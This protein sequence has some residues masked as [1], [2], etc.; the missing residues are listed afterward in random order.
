LLMINSEGFIQ[1]IQELFACRTDVFAVR[2]EKGSK[3]GYWPA[4]HY[5]PYRFRQHKF[6]GGTLNDFTEKEYKALTKEEIDKHLAGEQL[7]GIY[8]LLKDNTSWFIAADFDGD[9]W[10]EQSREF[11]KVCSENQIHAYLERSRS[12]NGGHVW[13]FFPKPYPAW[14]SRKVIIRLLEVAGVLSEFDKASSFDR[15]FPNQDILSGKGFGNL[16]AMPFNKNALERGNCCF[17]DPNTLEPCPDQ[18]TFLKAVEKTSLSIMDSLVNSPSHETTHSQSTALI[19]DVKSVVFRLNTNVYINKLALPLTFVNFLKDEL[20]I[21]N[22][23]FYIRK[24]LGKSIHETKRYFKLI[25]ERENDLVIPRGFLGNMIR[26][27]KENRIDFDFI[28]ERRRFPRTDL[29]KPNNI[30]LY[31]HQQGALEATRKKEFGVIVAPPGSGKTVIGL[32]IIEEKAQPALIIVHRKQLADQWMERIQT[33]LG[34]PRHLIGLISG[35]KAKPGKFITVAMIQSLSKA[36]E[37]NETKELMNSFGTVIVD[38]CHH[39]PAE[40]YQKAIS[41]LPTFYLYGLTATPFRKYSDGKLIFIYLGDVIYE[42]KTAEVPN[43]SKATI[44]IRNTTL[45]VPF[46]SK[47]DRFET[48]SKILIHDSARNMLILDD[49]IAEVK[50]GKKSVIITERKEHIDSLNQF[51]KQKF[52][53]IALSGDDNEAASKGKWNR[54]KSGDYQVLITTGQYFG[55]GTDLTNAHCLFLAYPFSFE[56]KLIQ[57]I[58]R[59]QRGEILPV[60]YDYRDIKIDYLNRLFLKRNTYYRKLERQA[61]LFDD[62]GTEITSNRT[63]IKIDEWI[64]VPV[65]DLEFRYGVIAFRYWVERMRETLEFEVENDQIRP[66]F[67]VLKPYFIKVLKSKLVTIHINAE[68]NQGRLISQIA[69]SNDLEKINK[70]VVDTVR[71]R[72]VER[73][74]FG[75]APSKETG[76]LSLSE[77]QNQNEQVFETETELLDAIINN[78]K[79]RHYRQLRYLANQHETSILKIRFVL[80]PFSF[81]FLLEGDEQYHIAM[82]TLDTEE[83]TYIWHVDKSIDDLKKRLKEIDSDLLSIRI[84]GRRSFLEKL[85]GNFTRVHHDYTEE[86]KGYIVWKSSL[87]ETLV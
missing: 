85:P 75:K 10:V 11:I 19:T 48:L 66:E 5:D 16:I 46:N 80:D 78:K 22:N 35:G 30:I 40:T 42:V 29:A 81:V 25:E 21:A 14:K 68:Y 79:V 53:V 13:I 49:V 43:Q 77:L 39:I 33:F 17:I 72:F 37:K 76:L 27:C 38:E 26:F 70:E 63:T 71:F 32:K 24:N 18:R 20:N 62:T 8:P 31:L 56:G 82:E 47:T 64:K 23:E 59:V 15:L 65:E 73:S 51:L 36:M 74:F 9:A 41:R 55:E 52:E 50:S 7:I 87:E 60:V 61:T 83:A 2:W 12:G 4:I 3:S 1:I 58:G 6:K 34:I 45:D 84:T 44:I 86:M 57:Y 54:L 69:W 28:D 67:E